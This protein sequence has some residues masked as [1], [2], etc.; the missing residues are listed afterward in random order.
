MAKK[1]VGISRVFVDQSLFKVD[2][3][4][5]GQIDEGRCQRPTSTLM[6]IYRVRLTIYQ[7]RLT[8]VSTLHI[9]LVLGYVGV[10]GSGEGEHRF[11]ALGALRVITVRE[12]Q[13]LLHCIG[14]GMVGVV[15]HGDPSQREE[16]RHAEF[17]FG[18]GA[19]GERFP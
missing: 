7:V 10:E 14:G 13:K 5:R 6:R 8:A 1:I 2:L 19:A 9:E 11:C 16:V 17:V 12:K 15:V 18:G 3:V 4:P